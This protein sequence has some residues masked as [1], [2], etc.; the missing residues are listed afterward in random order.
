MTDYI[1][2][3]E[4]AQRLGLSVPRVKQL[5]TSGRLHA[6]KIGRDWLILPAD[7]DAMPP[8]TIGRPPKPDALPVSIKRRGKPR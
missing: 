7:L 2:T 8:R 6:T 1:T 3:A 4:A 5:I